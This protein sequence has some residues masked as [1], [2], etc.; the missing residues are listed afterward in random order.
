MDYYQLY[1]D[2]QNELLIAKN[3]VYDKDIL[4]PISLYGQNNIIDYGQEFQNNFL[5]LLQNFSSN[6][7][8][9]HP[10]AG[11]LWYDTSSTPPKLKLY[12]DNNVWKQVQIGGNSPGVVTVVSNTSKITTQSTLSA[13]FVDPDGPITNIECNW[14]STAAPTKSLASTSSF[15]PSKPDYYY[16]EYTYN[17]AISQVTKTSAKSAV[18]TVVAVADNIGVA[19]L[20]GT[21]KVDQEI[22]VTVDD[23]DVPDPATYSYDWYLDGTTTAVATTKVGKY[24][25]KVPG[26][27]YVIVYYRDSV[28]TQATVTSTSNKIKVDYSDTP[29]GVGGFWKGGYYAGRIIDGTA[30]YDIIVAPKGKNSAGYVGESTQAIMFKT[31]ISTPPAE[32]VTNISGVKA[33][34][35]L[36]NSTH[37]AANF[38]ASIKG[39]YTDWYLPAIHELELLY[40]T[41]KPAGAL[42]TNV[43]LPYTANYDVYPSHDVYTNTTPARWS[44]AK[45]PEFGLAGSQ[46]FRI[47][48]V[49]ISCTTVGNNVVALSFNNGEQKQ[50]PLTT[51]GIV[52]AI[53]RVY[54]GEVPGNLIIAPPVVDD[55]VAQVEFNS[56]VTGTGSNTT[57]SIPLTVISGG[58]ITDGESVTPL[59]THGTITYSKTSPFAY[60]Q[61]TTGWSGDDVF[62][63]RVKN[64]IGWSNVKTITITTNKEILNSST[65]PPVIADIGGTAPYK[66]TTSTITLTPSITYPNGTITSV[67]IGPNQPAY[68]SSVS[69]SGGNILYTPQIISVGATDVFK[70]TVSNANGKSNVATVTVILEAKPVTTSTA[71]V[72]DNVI[73]TI[74][75][76]TPAAFYPGKFVSTGD[77]TGIGYAVTVGAGGG[78]LSQITDGSWDLWGISL[79]GTLSTGNYAYIGNTTWIVADSSTPVQNKDAGFVFA[80]T[81]NWTGTISF[82]Y[83]AYNSTYTPSSGA[84]PAGAIAATKK[85]TIIVQPNTTTNGVVPVMNNITVQVP[86]FVTGN[87]ASVF[88]FTGS[89]NGTIMY[90]RKT[91]EPTKGVATLSASTGEFDYLPNAGATGSDSFKY[92]AGN[93]FGESLEKTV[94]ITILA[95]GT[96]IDTAVPQIGSV[97]GSVKYNST[98][99]NIALTITN[100]HGVILSSTAG[101]TKATLG[102]ALFDGSTL[103]YTPRAN[104]TGVDRFSYYVSNSNGDSSENS[105]TITI[106]T[107]VIDGGTPPAA[108]VPVVGNITQSVKYNSVD[109]II[110]IP[111][112][113]GK[114]DTLVWDPVNIPTHYKTLTISSPPTTFK[115]TPETSFSGPITFAYTVKDGSVSSAPA[116]ISINVEPQKLPTYL[117]SILVQQTINEMIALRDAPVVGMNFRGG[118]YINS[119]N[120]IAGHPAINTIYIILNERDR[121]TKPT[122][123][124]YNTSSTPS[125]PAKPYITTG[126]K[127]STQYTGVDFCGGYRDF[128]STAIDGDGLAK[129]ICT[130]MRNESNLL[131]NQAKE[132]TTP[133]TNFVYHDWYIPSIRELELLYFWLKPDAT[134]NNTGTGA[135]SFAIPARGN[136]TSTVPG[137]TSELSYR[138][139]GANAFKSTVSPTSI[140]TFWSTT[141]SHSGAAGVSSMNFSDGAVINVATPDKTVAEFCT[142]RYVP[143]QNL[144]FTGTKYAGSALTV[145]INDISGYTDAVFT[146]WRAS[147]LEQV[148][149][150]LDGVFYPLYAGKYYVAATYTDYYNNVRC[151]VDPAITILDAPIPSKYGLAWGGGV[152]AGDLNLI[153]STSPGVNVDVKWRLVLAPVA[154]GEF[155][156]TEPSLTTINATNGVLGDVNTTNLLKSN[157]LAAQKVDDINSSGGINGYTDW[158]IPSNLELEM[159]YRHLKPITMNNSTTTGANIYAWAKTEQANYT[160]GNPARTS[161]AGYYLTGT[162]DKSVN[163]ALATYAANKTTLGTSTW[164]A[165]NSVI[166]RNMQNGSQTSL[167]VDTSTVIRYRLVRKVRAV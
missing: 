3:M 25:P 60:Y 90:Y 147:P 88:P 151:A 41:F 80:P 163:E 36:K 19:T 155:S 127:L 48:N 51:T 115:F 165:N 123:S 136:H 31:S 158:Y 133:I 110:T 125:S 100:A 78:V 20:I 86:G 87:N 144:K 71:P 164:T 131:L 167:V 139:S 68:A 95:V 82:D 108:D 6:T 46:E 33:N 138:S 101:K 106:E 92:V 4:L 44:N 1:V 145:T 32:T 153:E 126:A 61:P 156:V 141:T 132:T 8:M 73:H 129:S 148:D 93:E 21:G 34:A 134:P 146:L 17:D 56:K 103:T 96:P 26:T 111:L 137:V 116:K 43:T 157:R 75:A 7:A 77:V 58:S 57:N 119:L 63:Y 113:A 66:T 65:K 107:Q 39:D 40:Y 84:I 102:T 23:I 135:N 37:P 76:N 117:Y 94:T 42:S 143:A 9:P 11:M 105:V 112:E 160:I 162:T 28:N 30:F 49:Y 70:Y 2:K 55:V 52:R 99:N 54:A 104:T 81:T 35:N 79:S 50:I 152:W 118:K 166:V 150:S 149:R 13:S 97:T 18:I 130:A 159:I 154:G 83:T 98:A 122:S 12:T 142:I 27:Y 121:G 91:A 59:P 62:G 69:V 5:Y 47:S 45:V 89:F 114:Y 14:Y 161:V 124:Y 64:S 38:C 53:R 72:I 140:G 29:P 109:N 16:A 128:N 85:F 120:M 67:D 22:S 10:V 24:I 15:T 74:K